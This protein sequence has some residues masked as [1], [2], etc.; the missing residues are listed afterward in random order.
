MLPTCHLIHQLA[1]L[2]GAG[3]VLVSLFGWSPVP[4]ASASGIEPTAYGDYPDYQDYH[5]YQ[6]YR[7]YRR[8]RYERP[9]RFT[10]RKEKV[11]DPLWRIAVP[12]VPVSGISLLDRWVS[13]GKTERC[14]IPC[15]ACST[16][17]EPQRK[18]RYAPE[19][20]ALVG[21]T[22]RPCGPLPT[23]I[24]ASRRP[25]RCRSHDLSMIPTC[26]QHFTICG[27]AAMSG[28]PPPGRRQVLV[29]VRG[30]IDH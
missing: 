17:P 21:V 9:D 8:P 28:L 26:G 1:Q 14:L 16:I 6:D 13:C 15:S 22:Q 7:S 19:S 29:T 12:A 18:T 11:R 20:S 24:R 27:D 23:R 30:K 10:I 5:G 4:A 3:L 2:V 25:L